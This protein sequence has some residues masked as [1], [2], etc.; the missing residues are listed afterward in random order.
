MRKTRSPFRAFAR[1]VNTGWANVTGR[2]TEQSRGLILDSSQ[3]AEDA[4]DATLRHVTCQ[5]RG[6]GR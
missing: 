1:S 4:R 5:G 3:R 2:E 6:S